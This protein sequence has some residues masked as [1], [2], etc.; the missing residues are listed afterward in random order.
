MLGDASQMLD[1]GRWRHHRSCSA[2]GSI[3]ILADAI[4]YHTFDRLTYPH[5]WLGLG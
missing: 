5:G 2:D 4:V 3:A 1:P